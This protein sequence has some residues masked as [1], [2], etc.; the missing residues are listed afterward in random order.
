ME[1]FNQLTD[2]SWVL[3]SA[4]WVSLLTLVALEVV[5]GVDNI[6]FISIL[7]GKLPPEKRAA[8][9]KKGLAL[10]VIPRIVFLMLLGVILSMQHPLFSIPWPFEQGTDPHA[11]SAH[12]VPSGYLALTGQDLVLLVGG[13]FLIV[14]AVREIHHKLEGEGDGSHGHHGRRSAAGLG[15]V[16]M[17]IM[18]MNILFS[19]DSIIT[20]VGMT[21]GVPGAV[22]IMVL[23][24]VISTAIMV[25]AINP[26]SNFVERH[27]S[28]KM[29]ALAFL[30]LIGTNLLG[31]AAHIHVPKGYVY[32]A[33]A[34]SVFVEVLNI[35]SSGRRSEPVKLHPPA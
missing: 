25:V 19:L 30:L 4:A 22:P 7:T 35:K 34:F 31:E 2:W 15:A 11:D 5:L 10:A 1:I 12:P 32:F 14:Q 21:N 23:A 18:L 29:L 6:V 16:M 20:A 24:V 8:A 26:V 13:L 28:V 27:P 33:M 17:Q 9:R 3:T